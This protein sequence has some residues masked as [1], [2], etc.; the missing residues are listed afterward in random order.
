MCSIQSTKPSAIFRFIQSYRI[1]VLVFQIVVRFFYSNICLFL[2][3]LGMRSKSSAKSYGPHDS[4]QQNK[5]K[6]KCVPQQISVCDTTRVAHSRPF[7][8]QEMSISLI[9]SANDRSNGLRQTEIT[10]SHFLVFDVGE[11]SQFS[12][13]PTEPRCPFHELKACR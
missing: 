3:F 9:Y 5:F 6:Q 2:I 11:N 10:P 13:F 1:R 7:V 4:N 12:Y 8:A